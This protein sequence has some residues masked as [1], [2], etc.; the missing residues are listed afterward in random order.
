MSMAP[1]NPF[2]NPQQDSLSQQPVKQ[3]KGGSVWVWIFAIVGVLGLV[4]VMVCCGGGYFAYRQGTAFLADEIKV[5]L[6]GNPVIEENIGEIES[7]SMNFS[8]VVEEAQK[9]Q[10]QGNN[11]APPSLVFDIEGTKGSGRV[12]VRQDPSG[13]PD[14][15]ELIMS[16]GTRHKIELESPLFTPEEFEV[17]GF[18]PTDIDM[19]EPVDLTPPEIE[20]DTST[21]L[22]APAQ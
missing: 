22:E 15:L 12:L 14:A 3:K 4:G 17:E 13:Q 21:T 19:G 20:I 8:A 7:M 2:D 9:Q 10:E 6:D 16:D 11:E 5:K 18:D 1:N